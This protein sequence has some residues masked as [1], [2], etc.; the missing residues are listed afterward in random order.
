MVAVKSSP[1]LAASMSVRK[2]AF[3][4]A[5]HIDITTISQASRLPPKPV[6]QPPTGRDDSCIRCAHYVAIEEDLLSHQARQRN[7]TT[8]TLTRKWTFFCS[9]AAIVT[10]FEVHELETQ[11]RVSTVEPGFT[12]VLRPQCNF[13]FLTGQGGIN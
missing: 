10:S 1:R 2:I 12:L 8:A 9:L 4:S 5:T 13:F 7:N 3:A 6:P 11:Y